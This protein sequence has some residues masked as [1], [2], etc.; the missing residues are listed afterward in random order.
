MT[1]AIDVGNTDVVFGLWDGKAWKHQWRLPTIKDRQAELFYE[2]KLRDQFLELKLSLREVKTIIL[3]SVVPKLNQILKDECFRIFEKDIIVLG[4]EIFKQL[5]LTIPRPYEIGSDLVANSFAA[6]KLYQSNCIIVDFGTALTYTAVSKNGIMEG[7]SIAPG[8]KTAI[9]ALSSDTAQLPVV[10]LI[11]P[12]SAVG[13][14][15]VHAIQ[16][17]VLYGYTGMIKFMISKL[18]DEL[19]NGYKVIA[20]GGLSSILTDLHND[21]DHINK[22]LTLDGLR[23]IA[24]ELKV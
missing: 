19:G 10:P 24:S 8:I 9:A 6:W 4:P 15:T 14:D 23:L 20:T 12:Q 18:K 17:G 7:V 2:M 1:L 16:S 11:L 13:K 5:S 21:F 22:M 3:S